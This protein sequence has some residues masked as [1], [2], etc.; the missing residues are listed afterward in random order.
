M[1]L[2]RR[3][4]LGSGL[5]VLAGHAVARV[6]HA[7]EESPGAA[8]GAQASSLGSSTYGAAASGLDITRSLARFLSRISYDDLPSAAVHEAKRAVLD[9]VGASLSR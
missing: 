4:V 9:W 5:A 3:D 6:G 2:R 1:T 8:R 7:Q